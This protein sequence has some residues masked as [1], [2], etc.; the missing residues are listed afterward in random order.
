MTVNSYMDEEIPTGVHTTPSGGH[1][2]FHWC[3]QLTPESLLCGKSLND[4]GDSSAQ[5]ML[6]CE[7]PVSSIHRLGEEHIRGLSL[8]SMQ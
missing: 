4:V 3:C 5:S 7:S 1:C 6:L 2:S 8:I